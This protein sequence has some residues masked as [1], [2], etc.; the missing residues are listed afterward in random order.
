MP[1][2]QRLYITFARKTSSTKAQKYLS[3]GLVPGLP[4]GLLPPLPY[5][6][7]F[8][9]SDLTFLICQT[10]SLPKIPHDFIS[11][12][13]YQEQHSPSSFCISNPTILRLLS[14]LS[15]HVFL[16]KSHPANFLGCLSLLQE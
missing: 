13:V 1:Q 4:M 5:L 9:P 15:D 12:G 3:N 6:L 7:L 2:R 11:L 10:F 14:L 16:L 8:H